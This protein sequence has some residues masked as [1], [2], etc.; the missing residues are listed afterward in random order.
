MKFEIFNFESITST[1]DAAINLIKN[2][3]KSIGCIYAKNQTKGRGT[4]GNKWISIKG[5]LFMSLFF[6]LKNKYPSF[7]EFAIINPIII[8]EVIKKFIK[9]RQNLTIKF[10]N[11]LF[12]NKKKISGILQEIITLKRK[13]YLIIGVGLNLIDSPKKIKKYKT[14]NIFYETKKKT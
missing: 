5:N 1:N 10:P 7:S 2:K 8:S 13:K 9:K 6:P 14:T 12:L 4:H 11:D 3:K